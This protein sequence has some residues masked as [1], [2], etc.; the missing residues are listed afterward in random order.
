MKNPHLRA[1]GMGPFCPSFHPGAP[2]LLCKAGIPVLKQLEGG[3]NVAPLIGDPVGAALFSCG[4][5]KMKGSEALV[6]HP[7]FHIKLN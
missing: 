4:I 3:L 5:G 1:A 7:S 2:E 6:P